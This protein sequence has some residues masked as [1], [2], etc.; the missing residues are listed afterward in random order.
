MI[1][2]GV[3]S[4]D[5]ASAVV[6]WAV[7]LVL[8]ALFCWLVADV[9]RHGLPRLTASF[10]LSSPEDAG[11][12]GGI[13]PLLV[14]SL[15]VIAVCLPWVVVVGLGTAILLAE[16][17]P[18]GSRLGRTVSRSIN[19]LASMPSIVFGLFGNALFCRALGMGFSL[20]AGGLTLACMV[21]PFFTRAAEEGLRAVPAGY[22]VGAA[23]LGMSRTSTV[24]RVVLPSA[25]PGLLAGLLLGL[26]R[27]LAETAALLFTSGYVD[28]MPTSLLDSGRTLSVHIYDLTMNVGGGGEMASASALV[29]LIV[30]FL[31][32]RV[33]IYVGRKWSNHQTPQP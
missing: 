13:A 3:R 8:A 23:A 9:V 27:A 21:L 25:L 18:A 6:V 5:R 1:R 32:N 20:L 10:I 30:L 14:S 7:A 19:V 24:L 26:S 15:L 33:T 17:A 12:K 28:R 11:R 2:W 31:F 4:A 16:V 22:R 29:L